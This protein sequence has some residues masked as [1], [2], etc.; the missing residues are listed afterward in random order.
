MM[1][2]PVCMFECKALCPDTYNYIVYMHMQALGM[3]VICTCTCSFDLTVEKIA[4]FS[5]CRL[6]LGVH[7]LMI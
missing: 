5:K 1:D 7:D 4:I 3:D 2:I 6:F